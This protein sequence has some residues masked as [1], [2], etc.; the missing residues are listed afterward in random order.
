MA[1]A[2]N[3][4]R[5]SHPVGP[6]PI[7]ESDVAEVNR[8]F[9]DSF[10]ERYHRDGLIGVRVPPLSSAVWRYAIADADGGALLWRD[11]E[12]KAVAFNV[13]HCSGA[14]GWMGPLAVA[15]GYQNA[16]IGATVVKTAVDWLVRRG[17]RVVGLETMPRT[18]DNIGFYSRLGFEPGRLTLTVTLEAEPTVRPLTQ[19]SRLRPLDRDDAL[20]ECTALLQSL[21]P[22]YNYE[23]ESLLT[24]ELGLGD[25]LVLREGDDI[26]G[27]AICH[28]APLVEGR[29]REEVRVLKFVCAG[30]EHVLPLVRGTLDYSR[31]A[32]ARRAAVRVQTDYADC[33]RQL[34]G[35]GGRVRWSDL[36]MTAPGHG[37][38]VAQGGG[39][40]LSNWE[41]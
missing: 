8:L 9:S 41:I 21:A 2:T 14:E 6:F 32:G 26:A 13:A 25:T 20:A 4:S 24:E 23:R 16:G 34:I 18:M 38:S 30:G 27:F 17:A 33:Y 40:V 37:E 39:V 35:I 31:R 5:A 10:T 36:R 12:G 1:T 22:G 3:W 28:G 29:A 11:E 19:L 7:R 15:T